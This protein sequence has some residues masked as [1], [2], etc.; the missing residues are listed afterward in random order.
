MSLFQPSNRLRIAVAVLFLGTGRHSTHAQDLTSEANEAAWKDRALTEFPELGIKDSPLNKRFIFMVKQLREKAPQFFSDPA[1]PYRLAKSAVANEWPAK[2]RLAGRDPAL[3][4]RLEV[5]CDAALKEGI[6]RKEI[7]GDVKRFLEADGSLKWSAWP[8]LLELAEKYIP[9]TEEALTTFVRSVSL[10]GAELKENEQ[11]WVALVLAKVQF[12]KWV[13]VSHAE[14]LKLL[15]QLLPTLGDSREVLAWILGGKSHSLN[16]ARVSY[17]EVPK[18]TRLKVLDYLVHQRFQLGD[19]Y[20]TREQILETAIDLQ[21]WAVLFELSMEAWP[22]NLWADSR[23]PL[24]FSA[25]VKTDEWKEYFLALEVMH[26]N[27]LVPEEMLAAKTGGEPAK[28]TA[29]KG[30][31]AAPSAPKA[32][33]G[34]GK[35]EQCLL[36]RCLRFESPTDAA[37]WLTKVSQ[38]IGGLTDKNAHESRRVFVAMASYFKGTWK[39]SD[40]K[41]TGKSSK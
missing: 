15:V 38:G 29:A 20:F 35:L 5:L 37:A 24:Q 4:K 7:S 21:H 9:D 18:D 11:F 6:R 2:L 36:W 31:L 1:W 28:A 33:F 41:A 40:P 30:A 19:V 10:G 32:R 12:Q 16:G 13:E 23:A 34:P 17:E 22:S 8:E 26:K 14:Q 27:A 39:N 3:A 25:A